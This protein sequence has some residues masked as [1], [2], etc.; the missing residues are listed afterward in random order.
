MVNANRYAK[1]QIEIGAAQLDTEL[2]LWVDDDGPGIPASQRSRLFEPF[3]RLDES[4]N[5]DTGGHGLGLAIAAQIARCHSGRM[6][7]KA[8]SLGG[9]RLLLVWP[10]A[11]NATHAAMLSNLGTL[12][13]T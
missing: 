11:N 10:R 9:A 4:R 8:S 7:I 1:T 12:S 13:E 6:E 5:R 3:V 2:H